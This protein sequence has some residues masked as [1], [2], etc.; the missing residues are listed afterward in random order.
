MSWCFLFSQ[1]VTRALCC[2]LK[3][4]CA[5][6]YS[7]VKADFPD[8]NVLPFNHVTVLIYYSDKKVCQ[9][10]LHRDQ[11][12]SRDDK[13]LCHLNSQHEGTP[14]CILT[15]GDVRDLSFKLF[16]HGKKCKGS[17]STVQPCGGVGDYKFS[18]GHGS[19]FVLHP[20][21]ERPKFRPFYKQDDYCFFKHGDIKF[22][23]SNEMSIGIVCRTCI[24]ATKVHKKTGAHY[25][26]SVD[27]L[28]DSV[29]HFDSINV[30]SNFT[31]SKHQKEND[32]KN[33]ESIYRKI[34][35]RYLN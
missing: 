18:L 28:I 33:F 10:A 14:T 16:C 26:S 2:D 30:L 35:K 32:V 15:I 3:A 9:L 27:M 19:L 23:G 22:G 20:D 24:H 25:I 1:Q 11:L 29:E 13:F 7:F 8:I 34:Q 6:I 5:D 4:I 31:K 17:R 21:D 12:Y